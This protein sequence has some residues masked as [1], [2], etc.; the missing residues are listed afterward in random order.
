MTVHAANF[1]ATCSAYSF[2]PGSVLPLVGNTFEMS[3]SPYSFASALAGVMARCVRSVS[4]SALFRIEG[5]QLLCVR[6]SQPARATRLAAPNVPFRNC[7]RSIARSCFMVCSFMFVLHDKPPCDHRPNV[8]EETCQNH[9]DHVNDDK[10]DKGK[11]RNKVN[12]PRGL[13]PPEDREQPGERRIDRGRHREARQNNQWRRHKQHDDIREFLQHVVPFGLI[14]SGMSEDNMIFYGLADATEVLDSRSQV[15]G[16]MAA[17]QRI[18]REEQAIDDEKPG[19]KQVPLPSHRQNL[20]ARNGRPS[21]EGTTRAVR[22]AED[23]CGIELVAQ[24]GRDAAHLA[25]FSL[26]GTDRKQRLVTIGSV[27]PVEG[28]M[29]VEYLQSTHNQDD[30]T[31]NVE[32]MTDPHW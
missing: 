16:D 32:P 18:G 23:S 28:G 20:G 21:R 5:N 11:T 1:C 22:V 6:L 10:P 24:D 3:A 17:A 31:R 2:V 19:K 12:R 30:K 7:R 8:V 4:F 9:F 13:A 29:R 26:H 27:A 14:P 25:A 15:T